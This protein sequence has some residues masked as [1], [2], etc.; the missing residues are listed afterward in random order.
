MDQKREEL[1]GGKVEMRQASLDLNVELLGQEPEGMRFFQATAL[2][3]VW[4]TI[5]MPFHAVRQCRVGQVNAGV[6]GE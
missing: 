4:H 3:R 2:V 5:Q 1:S 6:Q